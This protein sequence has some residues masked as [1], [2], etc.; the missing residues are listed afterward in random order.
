MCIQKGKGTW[1]FPKNIGYRA[2][3]SNEKGTGQ[4]GHRRQLNPAALGGDRNLS[5]GNKL[6]LHC[7]ASPCSLPLCLRTLH[8]SSA[9]ATAQTPG[10]RLETVGTHSPLWAVKWDPATAAGGT[11]PCFQRGSSGARWAWGELP[12]VF[13]DW[14]LS[15]TDPLM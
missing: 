12:Q 4:A 5:T 3:G 9:R 10:A 11:D 1:N 2:G 15:H 13:S 8:I 14:L 6:C 7:S